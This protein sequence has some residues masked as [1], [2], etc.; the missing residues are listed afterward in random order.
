MT[1]H[2]AFLAKRLKMHNLTIDS[3][4]Q[5][6]EGETIESILS[7]FYADRRLGYLIEKRDHVP[8]APY[9]CRYDIESLTGWR[10][11]HCWAM[12]KFMRVHV[13]FSC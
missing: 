4:N 1:S 9:Y 8:I 7:R 2:E 12:L 5:K 6:E 10:R 11:R 13:A 3:S